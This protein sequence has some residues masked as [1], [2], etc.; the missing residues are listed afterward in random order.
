MCPVDCS[1]T[2]RH[3][4]AHAAAIA[5]WYQA[6][7]TVLYVFVNRPTMDLPA[8]LLDDADRDRLMDQLRQFTASVPSELSL[9]VRVEEAGYEWEEI[10]AQ[11]ESLHAD[12]LVLG[13]HGR[14]GF[15]HL[16]LGSVTEKVIRKA[17]CPTL[18][19]PPRAPGAGAGD[20]VQF[21]RLLCPVDFSD[22]SVNALTYALDLAQEVDG[23]LTVLHV[24]EMPVGLDDDVALEALKSA[25]AA[26]SADA[27]RRL[28][29]LIPEQ[30]RTYCTVD[31]VV[32]DGRAYRQILDQARERQA[33][34][35]VLGSSGRGALDR[36]M[37]GSTAHHVI[38]AAAC[39]VLVVR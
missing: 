39:P 6:R 13:T 18:V 36:L 33:E 3:A 37:F 5:R 21:H 11:A 15:Q 35:I 29:A 12:L 19:V 26:A 9:D 16:F 32:T 34:L 7:L 4:L 20:A 1:D 23:T 10:V 25:P 24:V 27:L 17:T 31:A 28:Q 2:S 30:A 22:S 38:R 14:S 8:F